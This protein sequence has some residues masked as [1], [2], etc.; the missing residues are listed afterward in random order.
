MGFLRTALLHCFL[1]QIFGFRILRRKCRQKIV[2]DRKL[3]RKLQLD[4]KFVT[5]HQIQIHRNDQEP[6]NWIAL[7]QFWACATCFSYRY[8][9]LHLLGRLTLPHFP[10]LLSWSQSCATVLRHALRHFLIM[11]A[12]SSRARQIAKNCNGVKWQNGKQ[13]GK[14]MKHEEKWICNSILLLLLCPHQKGHV[15]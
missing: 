11:R 7:N 2:C 3:V 15:S 1:S 6:Q 13:R 8:T 5:A 4:L 9:V 12:T 10:S 14:G